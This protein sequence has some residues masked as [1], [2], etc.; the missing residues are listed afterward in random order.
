MIDEPMPG[1][2][3]WDNEASAQPAT[4]IPDEVAGYDMLYSSGTTGRPKGIKRENEKNPI[5]LPNPFLKLLC[6]TMCGMSSESIYLSPAPLYHAAPLRFNMMAITLATTLGQALTAIA[7]IATDRLWLALPAVVAYGFCVSVAGIASQTLVQ[8]AS[9]RSMRGRV[10][11]IYTL[12]FLGGTPAG[13]PL[14]GW[15][16]QH[17][18]P[19]W[20]VG[21]GGLVSLVAALVG[22]YV[23][24]RVK[25]LS[26]R[27][28]L[29]AHSPARVAERFAA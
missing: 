3:S 20:A 7:I 1:F 18:G 17:V 15:I 27:E 29:A 9:E 12:V 22:A 8:L 24:A 11:S 4:P 5:D 10:M 14:V 19:R 28:R 26:L 23:L 2:R 21:V 16:G 25:E 6:A 13:A